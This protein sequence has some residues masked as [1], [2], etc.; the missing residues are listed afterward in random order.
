M[1][2]AYAGHRYLVVGSASGTFPGT[3]AGS[4]RVPLNYDSYT[5]QV[6]VQLHGPNYSGFSGYLDASGRATASLRVGAAAQPTLVG[7]VYHHAAVVLD[8]KTHEVLAA[9]NAA[10]V[11][12]L[13]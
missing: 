2:G 13:P 10:E 12:L 6:L 7:K 8:P 11:L 1:G 5:E 4:A 9:T 3:L